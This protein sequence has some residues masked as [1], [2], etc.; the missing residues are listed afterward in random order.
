MNKFF[1]TLTAFTVLIL[2]AGTPAQAALV[3]FSFDKDSGNPFKL[4]GDPNTN[5]DCSGYF[6]SGF[7]NCMIAFG[8]TDI[9]AVIIKF[10]VDEPTEINSSAFP[11]VNGREWRLESTGDSDT[12]KLSVGEWTYN[13]GEGDPDVRYWA[14]K[15]AAGFNLFWD[16]DQGALDKGVC[17]TV[18]SLAC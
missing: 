15:A 18:N 3:S 7:E 14:A 1:G 2:L 17:D 13:P 5:N 8:K 12:G 6:G 16:V 4:P 11:S 9:S 10:G